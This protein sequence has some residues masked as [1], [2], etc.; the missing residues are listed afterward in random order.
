MYKVGITGG[1]G[2]GKSTVCELLA[3]Y[4]IAIYNSDARA[5][6]LMAESAALRAAPL[7]AAMW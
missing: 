1:I 5:K 3:A 4:G 7:L 6:A 2:S